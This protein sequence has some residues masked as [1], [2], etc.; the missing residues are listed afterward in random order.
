VV[1]T[2]GRVEDGEGVVVRGRAV[3]GSVVRVVLVVRRDSMEAK[4]ACEGERGLLEV[5]ERA[6]ERERRRDWVSE[7]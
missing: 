4:R 5:V 7:W 2:I 1:L 6:A 3:E